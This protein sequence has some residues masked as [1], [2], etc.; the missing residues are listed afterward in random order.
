[1]FHVMMIM[2]FEGDG[3]RFGV[4]RFVGWVRNLGR[5]ERAGSDG[6]DDND[7]DVDG[8]SKRIE[9]HRGAVTD[10]IEVK[11]LVKVH[12]T[13][14][15]A[16]RAVGGVTLGEQALLIWILLA[17]SSSPPPSPPTPP[18]PPTTTTTTTTI[19]IIFDNNNTIVTAAATRYSQ[20]GSV[21][22]SWRQRSG[23]DHLIINIDK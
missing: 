5:G 2:M 14:A 20:R 17:L 23:Q 15:G 12:D 18:I 19:I 6:D 10:I 21:W 13:S 11:N 1:M 8:E 7:D 9:G 22:P 16:K 4:G 3:L